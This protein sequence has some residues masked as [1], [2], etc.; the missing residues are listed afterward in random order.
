MVVIHEGRPNFSEL[1]ADLARGDQDRLVYFAF[2]LLWLDGHDLRKLSQLARKELLKELI[3][4]N[5][6]EE[7][8]LYSEHHEGDGQALFEAAGKLKYE[9][10][11][12]KRV[13]SSLPI[14]AG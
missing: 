13:D 10:I 1:Q 11:I 12:Y 8:I 3:W 4:R 5:N 9:G 14:G 2:D 7:S 6:I